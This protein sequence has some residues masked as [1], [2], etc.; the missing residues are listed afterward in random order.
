VFTFDGTNTIGLPQWDRVP[1]YNEIIYQTD[2]DAGGS[3]GEYLTYIEGTSVSQYGCAGQLTIDSSGLRTGYGAQAI[4]EDIA[5]RMFARFAGA[6]EDL[7]GGAPVL[8]LTAFLMT[9][10]VWVGDYVYVSCTV[11]PNPFTGALGVVD[12]VYEVIDRNPNYAAGKM[13]YK[14]LDTGITGAPAAQAVGLAVIGTA[15]VY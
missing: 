3:Y 12:R 2:L 6:P 14:L 5:D 1:I 9:L 13:Q 11:M 15:T 7:K 8:D 4:T 10:P